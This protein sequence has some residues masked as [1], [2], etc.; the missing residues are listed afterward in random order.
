MT[1]HSTVSIQ[2]ATSAKLG[3]G[4]VAYDEVVIAEMSNV[5]ISDAVAEQGGG[6]Q[7]N[8]RLRVMSKSTLN[9]QNVKAGTNGGGLYALGDVDIAGGSTVNISNGQA[10]FGDGGGFQAGYELNVSNGSTLIILNATAGRFGGGFSTVGRVAM[11]NC[12]VTIKHATTAAQNTVQSEPPRTLSPSP[13][14]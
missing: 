8:Q 7:V 3:G 4:F 5:N 1:N 14:W 12:T 13:G 10:V 6:F 2:N 9:L 11:S